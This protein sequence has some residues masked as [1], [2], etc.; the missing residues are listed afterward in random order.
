MLLN[1]IILSLT[2]ETVEKFFAGDA[3]AAKFSFRNLD[4]LLKKFQS[5]LLVGK[6]YTLIKT[7]I[8][9]NK[10]IIK[11]LL[12]HKI[13]FIIKVKNYEKIL[14]QNYKTHSTKS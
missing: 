1:G 7:M 4:I 11:F 10:Q 9:L 14:I 3:C 2:A 13:F 8:Y 6:P 5:V 12:N